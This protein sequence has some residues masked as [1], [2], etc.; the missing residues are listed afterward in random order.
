MSVFLKALFDRDIRFEFPRLWHTKGQTLR[1]YVAACGSNDWADTRSCW[2]DNRNVSVDH[3]RR[4]CG[5]CAACMLRRLSVHAAGLT[6]AP[7]TY[8]WEDLRAPSFERGAAKGF[9]KISA[10]RHYAIA[11]A[12]H[13]D[14]L[15]WVRHSQIHAS[16]LDLNIHQLALA[17]GQPK[18][19]VR[20][21]LIR[22]LSQHE[23]EWKA[24]M[25]FLGSDSFVSRW[26]ERKHAN[27][28]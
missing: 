21:G 18:Q 17:L 22:M 9:K 26:T 12:L 28:A 10:Q 7:E 14:H 19:E 11:G 6:E 8:I 3:E 1:D 15:A 16:R 4:Q 20:A 13:L 23:K 5:V 24:F 25:E 27:A 2:Q